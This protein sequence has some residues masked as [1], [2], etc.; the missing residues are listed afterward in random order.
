MGDKVRVWTPELIARVKE[1]GKTKTRTEIADILDMSLYSIKNGVQRHKI[2]CVNQPIL[3]WKKERIEELRQIMASGATFNEAA[4]ALRE[5]LATIKYRCR[6]YKIDNTSR[7]SASCKP[8]QQR[9]T[10]PK[11]KHITIDD[12][13]LIHKDNLICKRWH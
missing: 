12:L 13:K 2:K 6:I 3:R 4:K 8:I 1:L 11:P 10:P 5:T 9:K 7:R